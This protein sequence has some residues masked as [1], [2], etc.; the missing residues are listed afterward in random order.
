MDRET[1]GLISEKIDYAFEKQP[2][3]KTIN[4]ILE[5]DDRVVSQEDLAL[6]YFIG[7]L[8][9]IAYDI[10]FHKKLNE[11]CDKMFKKELEKIYGKEG[12]TERLK[13]D[14]IILEE[15]KA[16][17]GRRIKAEL[18]EEEIGDIRN[19]LIPM[20]VPFREKMRKEVVL[21]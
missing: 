20:I 5:A 10:A 18:T 15:T 9:N 17:G 1:R 4:W 6:G 2:L 8:M 21:R 16:K 14:D 7:S 13:E 19:M 12:A 11:K 3:L